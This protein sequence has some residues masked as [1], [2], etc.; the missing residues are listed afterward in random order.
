MLPDGQ[1]IERFGYLAVF[2]TS[3]LGSASLFVPIPG[4]A[5]LA[6]AGAVLSPVL[7]GLA[8]GAGSALGELTGYLFGRAALARWNGHWVISW[9][10]H[11]TALMLFLLSLVPNPLF[12]V[13]G[14][15]AGAIRYPLWRFLLVV[16]VGK[17]L[18]YAGLAFAGGWGL[19]LLGW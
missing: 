18:K 17:S 9:T 14:V 5:I 16:G 8:A 2:L 1:L 6:A 12:D 19:G 13:A 7:V 15:C 4:W 3:L 10:R 11:R